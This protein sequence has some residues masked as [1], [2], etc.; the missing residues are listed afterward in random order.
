MKLK[1]KGR[2]RKTKRKYM[3]PSIFITIFYFGPTIHFLIIEFEKVK[4]NSLKNGDRKRNLLVIM[5][6]E[7]K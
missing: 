1:Y 4:R 3:T 6:W 2:K 5:S 7:P